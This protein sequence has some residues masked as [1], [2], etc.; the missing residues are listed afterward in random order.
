MRQI[1]ERLESQEEIISKLNQL[2]TQNN[3]LIV[4]R[5][6]DELLRE[7]ERDCHTKFA[8]LEEVKQLIKG[9]S[10]LKQQNFNL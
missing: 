9:D 4:S 7:L 3:T 6:P 2:N 8:N 10:L 1:N 5:N